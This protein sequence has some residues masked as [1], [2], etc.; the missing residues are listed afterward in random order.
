M[1]LSLRSFKIC[2]SGMGPS[3]FVGFERYWCFSFFFRMCPLTDVSASRSWF[4]FSRWDCII[5]LSIQNGKQ[6]RH[7][8]DLCKAGAL[9]LFTKHWIIEEFGGLAFNKTP[10]NSAAASTRDKGD[11]HGRHQ[12]WEDCCWFLCSSYLIILGKVQ[13]FYIFID[14]PLFSLYPSV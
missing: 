8:L 13:L 11:E 5:Y 2:K 14:V 4:H 10:W 12:P 1:W 7:H 6:K 9:K 3:W